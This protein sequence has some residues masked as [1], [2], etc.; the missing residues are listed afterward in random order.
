ML[1]RYLLVVFVCL[2][3]SA[4]GF[5]IRN[6]ADMPPQLRILTI[7]NA[8]VHS[9]LTSQLAANLESLGVTIVKPSRPAPFTLS[10]LADSFSQTNSVLGT[11][12][13]LNTITLNYAVTFAIRDAQ[14]H[15]IILPSTIIS[16]TAYLQNASQVLG[17]TAAIPQLQQA[18][19]RDMIQK[20]LAKLAAQNTRQALE[21]PLQ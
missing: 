16:S 5:H 11:A 12:Q 6:Q 4:C 15:Y 8:N 19:I 21:K 1:N 13:Q 14:G 17:D 7:E 3:L 20:I 18:L 10:I 9:S 2:M